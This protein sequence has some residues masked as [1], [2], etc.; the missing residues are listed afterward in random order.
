MIHHAC[1]IRLPMLDLMCSLSSNV[2]SLTSLTSSRSIHAKLFA[3][4]HRFISLSSP[5]VSFNL[6]IFSV[7]SAWPTQSSVLSSNNAFCQCE[8]SS[9]CSADFVWWLQSL[10]T[11]QTL[12][13]ILS[14]RHFFFF[15]ILRVPWI[16]WAIK[17]LLMIERFTVMNEWKIMSV[18]R[19]EG[20][21]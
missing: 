7:F 5:L 8:C 9:L 1:R 11:R 3:I 6:N 19:T 15:C 4:N 21:G 10:I 16:W 2:E 20:G 18:N 12:S 13:W 17:Q 14:L